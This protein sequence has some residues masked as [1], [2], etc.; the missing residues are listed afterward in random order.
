MLSMNPFLAYKQ[1]SLVRWRIAF[2]AA[3]VV[4]GIFIGAI[5][6]R[7]SRTF[8]IAENVDG[9]LYRLVEGKTE[10]ILAG[11]RIVLGEIVRSNGGSGSA[12]VL[13]DGSRIEMRTKSELWF[14]RAKDGIG[15]HLRQGS[16]I[17]NAAKQGNGH[18]YVKTKDVIVSV[19]GTVFLVNAEEEGSRVA[20]I[21]GEV[22]VN[23][24]TEEKRLGSGQQVATNPAMQSIAREGRNL[25]EPRCLGARCA[26]A[27][28]DERRAATPRQDANEERVAFE[29][30]S[31]RPGTPALP[32][33]GPRAA[34]GGREAAADNIRK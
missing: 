15:I 27:A 17:V 29:E 6:W 4:M 2:A 9:G 10:A 13:Q 1:L 21:E 22:R 18:L 5:A 32:G 16:V 33:G 8:A 12:L 3:V 24:G 26:L 23:Q 20:V 31:I 28:I 19:V 11:E 30:A 7:Q 14:E 25:L 34:A